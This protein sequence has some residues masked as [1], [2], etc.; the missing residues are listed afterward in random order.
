[1]IPSS[2]RMKHPSSLSLSLPRQFDRWLAEPAPDHYF[3]ITECALSAASSLEST[4]F[5]VEILPEA[6]LSASPSRPNLVKPHL[7]REALQKVSGPIKPN[8]VRT[9]LVIPDYAVRMAILDFDHFPPDDSER[10]ALIRFRLRKTVPF[11][12][13]E[14]PVSYSIQSTRQGHV[15]VLVVAV[16]DPILKEY[17]SLFTEAGFRVGLVLPSSLAAL[18]RCEVPKEGVT[19]FVRTDGRTVSLFLLER[20]RVRLVR[21]LDLTSAEDESVLT[22]HSEAVIPLLEQTLAFAEDQLGVPVSSILLSGFGSETEVIS[23]AINEQSGIACQTPAADAA[24]GTSPG[25]GLLGL[26]EQLRSHAISSVN[27]ASRPFARERAQKAGLVT[28]C[29]VLSCSLL[30]MLGFMMHEQLGA[31]KIRKSL[32][33]QTAGLHSLQLEQ[34]R[35]LSILTQ[36]QNADVF[37]WSVL[38]NELIAHRGLSWARIFEDLSTVLPP[39]M[40][41]I[42]IRL[43]QVTEENVNGMDRV[44]LDMVVA[45][46]QPATLL[47]LLRGL[48]SSDLFDSAKVMSQTSP[49]QDDPTCKFRI[50][51]SYAQ[52]I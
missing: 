5:M 47:D 9:A 42:G 50:L 18:S 10:L 8:R 2:V 33:E 39:N 7:Y 17:E 40:R 20:E 11:H 41:L 51:V 36:P 25:L 43:P 19:A 21:C 37:A 48:Q 35:Y 16:A 44:Q 49:T 24:D 31:R 14:A 4:D 6:G 23:A 29:I 28:A 15:E 1:M 45:T 46:D 13:D 32:A 3:E 30:L 34:T 38:L 26:L 27:I 22:P 52:K 12:I